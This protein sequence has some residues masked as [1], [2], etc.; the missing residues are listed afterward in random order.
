MPVWF[1]SLVNKIRK[2][3]KLIKADYQSVK[4]GEGYD[5]YEFTDP[6]LPNKKRYMTEYKQAGTIE[7]SGRG[8]DMQATELRFIP[9]EENITVTE[10]GKKEFYENYNKVLEYDKVIKARNA[11]SQGAFSNIINGFDRG[12]IS[13][14]DVN[15]S[16]DGTGYNFEPVEVDGLITGYALK[17]D[18]KTVAEDGLLNIDVST[19]D[20]APVPAL[21]QNVNIQAYITENFTNEEISKTY[22]ILYPLL[23][24]HLKALQVEEDKRFSAID[25]T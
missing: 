23:S 24:T 12:V 3:G 25:S 4:E 7:I 10:K 17:K 16:L 18:G 20:A 6:S 8:D 14:E 1:P 11:E 15:F 5:Y 21:R 19:G 2:E 22:N 9:G 13:A